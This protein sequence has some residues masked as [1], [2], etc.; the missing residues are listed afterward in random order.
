MPDFAPKEDVMV[1]VENGQE[2]VKLLFKKRNMVLAG[3]LKNG[4][5]VF[6]NVP[7]GAEVELVGS[8]AKGTQIF[9]AK[10]TQKVTKGNNNFVLNYAPCAIDEFKEKLAMLN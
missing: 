1:R 7:L 3:E 6:K 9:Y 4:F 2:E 8:Y 10:E 5:Y